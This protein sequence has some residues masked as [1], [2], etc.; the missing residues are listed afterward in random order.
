MTTLTI[1][2]GVL[3]GCLLSVLVGLVGSRRRIGFARA[4]FIS[5][6]LSPFVGLIVALV[7]D[8]LPPGDYRWGFLHVGFVVLTVLAL[9]VFL[10]L[11][12][13]GGT[14]FVAGN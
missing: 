6:I 7:S 12:L 13:T 14:L 2:L 11:L 1:F 10:V 3:T 4:F 5:L 9:A 8:P